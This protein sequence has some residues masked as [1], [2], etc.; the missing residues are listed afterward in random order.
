MAKFELTKTIEAVKLNKRTMRVL[1]DDRYTIPYGSVLNDVTKE[2]D[3]RRFFYLG[4]PY[5]C[6]E[7][8]IGSAL[9]EIGK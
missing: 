5:E 1:S 6:P 3:N 9:K 4:E 8:V 7:M 2:G